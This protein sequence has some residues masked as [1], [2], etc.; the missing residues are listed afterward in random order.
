M[1]AIGSCLLI[2]AGLLAG[3]ATLQRWRRLM[4][5]P[6]YSDIHC[7]PRIARDVW[8][9]RLGWAAPIALP[10]LFLF[11]WTYVLAQGIGR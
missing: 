10:L 6:E 7:L 8:I 1:V 11:A 3:V 4:K 9:I 5:T 2:F